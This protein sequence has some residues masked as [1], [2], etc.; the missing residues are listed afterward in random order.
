MMTKEQ[1]DALPR[2][3]QDQILKT[4]EEVQAKLK[5][6]S[7]APATPQLDMADFKGK[8]EDV[9]KNFMKSMTDVDRKYFM[10]PGIGTEGQDDKSPV[11]KYI[12]TVKF[13]KA[14]I[15]NDRPILKE[16]SDEVR[17]KANLSEGVDA[18]GGFLVP[19]EF[20]SEVLRLAP[21]YGV[22][23][24]N[25][26]FV[27]MSTDTKNFPAA[28]TTG[29]SAIWINEGAQI[30]Q[31]NPTWTQVQLVVKKLG[32]LP[33][34]TNELLAD[35][36]IDTMQYL[37]T[38]ISEAF[39]QAEDDAGFNG[40]ASPF[41]GVCGATGVPTYPHAGGTG[42]ET[43]SY[44]D[45]IRVTGQIYSNALANAKFYFHRTMNAYIK[46]RT[47]TAGAPLFPSG[48]RDYL[49][50]AYEDVEV[51]PGLQHTAYRT[52]GTTYAVFGD[53]Q[54][55]LMLGQRS[56]ITMKISDQATVDS[57]NMFEKDMVALRAIERICIAV[58]LP[59]AFCVIRAS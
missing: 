31:T 49:G 22:I 5:I 24:R 21:L 55:G 54:R 26:R 28:G 50:Y 47:T 44:Q 25:A 7:P 33:K 57:D 1:F 17:K 29:Q 41:I 11:A 36:N 40:G 12:K 35:A 42:F 59:S 3:Q 56:G 8:V 14:L 20:E 34:V 6:M 10:F 16:M 15:N 32:A 4:M 39:A 52:T 45:L 30:K 53:L 46:S 2:E 43:L 27:P 38:L 58:A 51:L 23:R 19:Q 13:M 9:M 18:S 37:A 48:A